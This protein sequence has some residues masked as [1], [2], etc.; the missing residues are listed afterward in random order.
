MRRYIAV[1][2]GRLFLYQLLGILQASPKPYHH[3][4]LNLGMRSE[5]AWWSLFLQEWNGVPVFYHGLPSVRV[6]IDAS[7]SFGCGAIFLDGAWFGHKWPLD[8]SAKVV[9]PVVLT[10]ALWG[11]HWEETNIFFYADNLA[12]VQ[13][14]ENLSA[15][16]FCS[17][18]SYDGC[19]STLL[20]IL[21]HLLQNIYISGVKNV[22]VDAFSCSNLPT[23]YS[24]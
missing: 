15:T 11:P 7:S 24:S 18:T 4:C 17:A 1:Q 9:L 20:I 6:D 8:W 12:M 14:V 22:A 21:L 2:P 3:V 23:H 16:G 5:L 10:A 13:L 19:T